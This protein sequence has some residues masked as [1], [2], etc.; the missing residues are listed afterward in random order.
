VSGR[1]CSL[2]EALVD[3]LC[4]RYLRAASGKHGILLLVHQDVRKWI[5]TETGTVLSF[6]EVVARLS[7]IALKISVG[8]NDAPQPL[9]CVLDVSGC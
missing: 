4:G 2:E 5:D 3:Q 8:R 7:A 6:K 1:S 9:V